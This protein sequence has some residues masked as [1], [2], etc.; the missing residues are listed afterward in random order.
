MSPALQ[1]IKSPWNCFAYTITLV[2]ARQRL[3]AHDARSAS[4]SWDEPTITS[5]PLR[6]PGQDRDF[7]TLVRPAAAS[8][9]ILAI[10]LLRNCN[11]DRHSLIFCRLFG[12]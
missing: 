4:W 5:L 11:L 2:T 12:V 10:T 9:R 8:I 3:G 1:W 7:T 6:A